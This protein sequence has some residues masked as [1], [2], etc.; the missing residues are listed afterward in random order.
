MRN[1]RNGREQTRALRAS[2]QPQGGAGWGRF[3]LG[4]VAA[5]PGAGRGAAACTGSAPA[6]VGAALRLWQAQNLWKRSARTEN[7]EF[8]FSQPIKCMENKLFFSLNPPPPLPQ[9]AKR[10]LSYVKLVG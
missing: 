4:A 7:V 9:P 5:L 3:I 6:R 8:S 2:S 1:S 10:C